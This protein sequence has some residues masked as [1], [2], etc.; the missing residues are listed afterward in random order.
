M[1]QSMTRF[2]CNI[3]CFYFISCISTADVEGRKK[4][5]GWASDNTKCDL[6]S[7]KSEVATLVFLILLSSLFVIFLSSYC[8]I[9]LQYTKTSRLF[10]IDLLR[11]MHA[12]RT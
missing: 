6:S 3:M 7:R 12:S 10:P 8:G 4:A 5:C 11:S 2:Q 1:Y 9:V